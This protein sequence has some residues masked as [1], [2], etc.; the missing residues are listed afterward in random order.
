MPAFD[1]I[2]HNEVNFLQPD[3]HDTPEFLGLYTALYEHLGQAQTMSPLITLGDRESSN[4][5]SC[6][7]IAGYICCFRVS[8]SSLMF[9]G[10][11]V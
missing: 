7:S 11:A 9:S 6:A 8:D 2:S 1:M 3:T 5:A 10:H 4:L